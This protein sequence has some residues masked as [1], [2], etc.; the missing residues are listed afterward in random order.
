M[1]SKAALWA[2]SEQRYK[3]MVDQAQKHAKQVEATAEALKADS[4]TSLQAKLKERVAEGEA[5][6]ARL[7]EAD[8]QSHVAAEELKSKLQLSL[9]DMAIKE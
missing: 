6:K 4:W 9:K 5:L 3:D 1:S 2:E 8:Q 7:A